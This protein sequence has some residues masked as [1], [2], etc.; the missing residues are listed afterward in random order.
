[1]SMTRNVLENGEAACESDIFCGG[2]DCENGTQ[3]AARLR[4]FKVG[5]VLD[6]YS[7]IFI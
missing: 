5:W 2:K 1:M 7:V 3:I 6:I 4:A